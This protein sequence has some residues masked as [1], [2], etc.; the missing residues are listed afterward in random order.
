MDFPQ[1]TAPAHLGSPQDCEAGDHDQPYRFGWRPRAS[2]PYPFSTR[3]YARLLILRSRIQ[4]DPKDDRSCDG[5]C[6][7]PAAA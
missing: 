3:Q 4:D 6:S 5:A 1:Q 7:P 2:A